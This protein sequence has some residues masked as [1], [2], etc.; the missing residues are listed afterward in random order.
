M[1]LNLGLLNHLRVV[2]RITTCRFFLTLTMVWRQ[3][4]TFI[5]KQL[6]FPRDINIFFQM[7]NEGVFMRST[8]LYM[9][10]KACPAWRVQ[11][12]VSDHNYSTN[13]RSSNFRWQRSRIIFV[14]DKWKWIMKLNECFR[15]LSIINTAFDQCAYPQ[16]SKAYTTP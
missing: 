7:L 2:K 3:S 4:R 11:E 12:N 15:P 16:S 6:Y 5:N 13:T 1:I 9:V 10:H 8:G 14:S